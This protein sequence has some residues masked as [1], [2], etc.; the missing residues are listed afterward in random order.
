MGVSLEIYRARIGTFSG[1][2][3]SSSFI[4]HITLMLLMLH[5]GVFIWLVFLIVLSGDIETNPGP[6][7]LINGFLL[8]TRSVKS[9]NAYRNKLVELQALVQLKKAKIIC[10][11]ETWLTSDM[12]DS[13]MLPSDEFKIYRKDRSG[14]GGVLTAVHN[15]I[16]SKLRRDLMPANPNHNE[17][18]VVEIKFPKRPKMA[19]VNIYNSPTNPNSRDKQTKMLSSQN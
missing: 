12:L 3:D 8:N 17:I 1:C 4:N 7:N 14:H 16:P 9:V 10:L 13:E 15:S 18:I 19:L 5:H 11:T 2:G 6:P